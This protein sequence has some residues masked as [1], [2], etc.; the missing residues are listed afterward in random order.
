M[1]LVGNDA[2]GQITVFG[3]NYTTTPF[4]EDSTGL[5]IG[6]GDD[7]IDIGNDNMGVFVYG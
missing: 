1:I 3:D 7:I 6:D 5:N 4:I 2:G